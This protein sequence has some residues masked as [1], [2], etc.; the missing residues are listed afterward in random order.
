M[1]ADL[2]PPDVV[3]LCP[4][5]VS[6]G[7][8]EQTHSPLS[9]A[10]NSPR[11]RNS[12]NRRHPVGEDKDE[13]GEMPAAI[14]TSDAPFDE[15]AP[16]D[17]K[18][19]DGDDELMGKYNV[20]TIR[21]TTSRTRMEDDSSQ[22]P[23]LTIHSDN[24]R[25]FGNDPQIMPRKPS[26]LRQRAK[27]TGDLRP[28]MEDLKQKYLTLSPNHTSQHY[29]KPSADMQQHLKFAAL[30]R[31]IVSINNQQ[32]E[33]YT[34]SVTTAE[35]EA[36]LMLPVAVTPVQGLK[37]PPK[38]VK[39]QMWSS[40]RTGNARSNQL[41]NI[42]SPSPHSTDAAWSSFYD[43]SYEAEDIPLSLKPKTN[44]SMVSP[45]GGTNHHRHASYAS[46][47][48]GDIPLLT[49]SKSRRITD[50]SYNV[51]HDHMH[52]HHPKAYS[53]EEMEDLVRG[54]GSITK[55]NSYDS[56]PHHEASIEGDDD[57]PHDEKLHPWAQATSSLTPPKQSE[58]EMEN[59]QNQHFSPFHPQGAVRLSR[60]ESE[61]SDMVK[62]VQTK[63]KEFQELAL[64][65]TADVPALF[66]STLS[67][68]MSDAVG[69]AAT[70]VASMGDLAF[71]DN[72]PSAVWGRAV[73]LKQGDVSARAASDAGPVLHPEAAD[74][75]NF[76]KNKGV[77]SK[78]SCS[79]P[80]SAVCVD[81]MNI[82][83]GN[84]EE[85][86]NSLVHSSVASSKAKPQENYPKMTPKKDFQTSEKSAAWLQEEFRRRSI[87][88]QKINEAILSPS[89]TPTEAVKEQFA[90]DL[91]K[92][93]DELQ[94]EDTGSATDDEVAAITEDKDEDSLT[95]SLPSGR[96]NNTN[97]HDGVEQGFEMQYCKK[98]ADDKPLPRRLDF[99][100][101]KR[102]D[103]QEISRPYSALG[104][105]VPT[106]RSADTRSAH[107]YDKE[108]RLAP[109]GNM[110]SSSNNP[111]SVRD[112]AVGRTNPVG[113]AAESY[114]SA[115]PPAGARH[116]NVADDSLNTSLQEEMQ[117]FVDDTRAALRQEGSDGKPSDSYVKGD[118][119]L[120]HSPFRSIAVSSSDAPSDGRTNHADD[121]DLQITYPVQSATDNPQVSASIA[122][123]LTYRSVSE[124]ASSCTSDYSDM[125]SSKP[126]L[127]Q[128]MDN[129]YGIAKGDITL[130]LLNENTGRIENSPK[131]TWANRVHGAI[132]RCRRMRRQMGG[133]PGRAADP[134]GS[135]QGRTSL[136]VDMDKARVAGGFKSVASTQEAALNHLRHDEVDEAIELF[137]D[138]IFAYYSYFEKTLKARELNPGSRDANGSTNFKPYIGVALH[139]LGILHLLN[140]EYEEALSFFSRA[141]ENRKACIGEG[142]RDHVV[143]HDLLRCI[144]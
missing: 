90:D 28:A 25:D 15:H 18:K 110:H 86:S 11:S 95:K 81:W 132:W 98:S 137:E 78:N 121:M 49:S 35:L 126:A 12:P 41:Q 66:A 141:V 122:R 111:R 105:K 108:P 36:P 131:S 103:P 40:D 39:K 100:G 82:S 46:Y 56:Q 23:A 88:K 30:K 13:E 89:E 7:M 48:S 93:L 73:L 125:Q 75:V 92:A 143:S 112:G 22:P 45:K 55:T 84:T 58:R 129:M 117:R 101:S 119:N 79:A 127:I 135:P 10:P 42:V 70:G 104:A 139:N 97:Q 26:M 17:E 144:V 94:A 61:P 53:V 47:E 69:L 34:S 43:N 6:M 83:N 54:S 134:S 14:R 136:P 106:D 74:W 65:D 57:Q 4:S 29:R 85:D 8:S 99:Q 19:T 118:S 140:G 130:S 24:R 59:Q 109:S 87:I 37:S 63:R 138:I 60:A 76:L 133:F 31:D 1:E 116:T 50:E 96:D 91:T 38:V 102:E 52:A 123:S 44:F 68:A 27:T 142:H 120:L 71:G 107:V 9:S 114:T 128:C 5:G 33:P 20:T 80:P 64:P 72:E 115:A 51:Y 2:Y 62:E 16:D 124:G 77:D 21:R 113:R 32:A 67:E 3:T